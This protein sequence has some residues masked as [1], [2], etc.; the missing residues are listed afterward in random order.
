MLLTFYKGFEI[1]LW[2]ST[3]DLLHHDHNVHQNHQQLG[4]GFGISII[5]CISYSLWI[6]IQVLK[7]SF[8]FSWF[9]LFTLLWLTTLIFS[10]FGRRKWVRSTHVHCQVHFWWL[11]LDQYKHLYMLYLVIGNGINGSL[12]GILGFVLWFIW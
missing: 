8:M 6:I 12:G 7:L 2:H 1:N 3:I 5:A 4:L 11:C 10:L 9:D